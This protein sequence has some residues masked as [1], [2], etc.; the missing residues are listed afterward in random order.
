MCQWERKV[1]ENVTFMFLFCYS[2]E[3]ENLLS[4]MKT[5][6]MINIRQEFDG[7]FSLV[8]LSYLGHCQ[9]QAS[10]LE[11]PTHHS[12]RTL[13]CVPH[14]ERWSDLPVGTVAKNNSNCILFFST[15]SELS[16]PIS[17]FIRHLKLWLLIK[18]LVQLS[19]VIIFA[20]SRAFV[21]SNICYMT[22]M[23]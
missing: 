3:I 1:S 11:K 17:H 7:T 10:C 12:L 15:Y 19:I 5:S 8:C 22:M 23:S 9:P 16:L 18:S 4:E 13:Q 2:E 20:L 14:F 6:V 21:H